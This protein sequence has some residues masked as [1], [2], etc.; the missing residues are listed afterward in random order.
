[1]DEQY[2][3]HHGIQGQKH[4]IRRYQN[5]DGS[6][7]DEGR[8]RYG[9]GPARG[10]KESVKDKI[11]SA[12]EKKK[13]EKVAARE[14]NAQMSYEEHKARLRQSIVNNPK[15]IVKYNKAFTKDEV[16]DIIS[17]IEW[18]RKMQD[19]KR[20]E[21]QRRMQKIK[22]MSDKLGTFSNLSKNS[23]DLWNNAAAINNALVT[24]GKFKN[25]KML[26]KV[27]WDKGK[28]NKDKSGD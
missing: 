20:S 19:I 8:R 11:K 26:P 14:K 21:S 4:G 18:N 24:S 10:S 16:K 9:I 12:H 3:E 28:D 5:L 25:G 23:I 17:E 22:D 27:G 1:M 13:A 2:L 15:K 6:L 7:T